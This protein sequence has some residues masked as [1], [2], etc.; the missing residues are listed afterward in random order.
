MAWQY[1]QASFRGVEFFV[2]SHELKGGQRVQVTEFPGRD[3]ANTQSFGKKNKSHTFDAYVIGPDY[4][5]QR[6]L[7]I[8]ALDTVGAGKL[9]HP[10]LGNINVLTPDWAMRESST[11]LNIARFSIA[12]VESS[13]LLA[14]TEVVDTKGAVATAKADSL[15]TQKSDFE[16]KYSVFDKAITIA[17]A[18]ERALNKAIDSIQTSKGTVSGNVLYSRNLE[19][20]KL[21]TVALVRNAGELFDSVA[22]LIGFGTNAD[23]DQPATPDN[24]RGSYQDLKALAE[25]QAD[26]ILTED[27]DDPTL[28]LQEAIKLI[29]L[30]NQAAVLSFIDF[31]SADEAETIRSE[32]FVLLDNFI[33]SPVQRRSLLRPLKLQFVITA[34]SL[35]LLRPSQWISQLNF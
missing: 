25:F 4:D 2:K 26:E 23:D 15:A 31:K 6:G 32:I 8:T 7:L 27:A 35:N 1:R 33:E 12:Y 13:D 24:A 9:V 10:Y 34:C 17:K 29:S 21:K 19:L 30:T 20:I 18:T 28:L 5:Q 3:Q 16:S 14:P 11:Q 22:E